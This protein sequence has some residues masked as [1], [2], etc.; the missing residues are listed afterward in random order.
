MRFSLRALLVVILGISVLC[1]LLFSVPDRFAL[2]I[3][4][5]I[6]LHAT[7]AMVLGIVYFDREVRAF[8]V[9]ASAGMANTVLLNMLYSSSMVLEEVAAFLQGVTTTDAVDDYFFGKLIFVYV[10]SVSLTGGWI[11]VLA[12]QFACR[13]KRHACD[14]E[15]PRTTESEQV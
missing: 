14:S 1:A 10:L 8:C 15:L 11:G 9:G 13:R 7:V 4:L 5:M 6:S 2:F 12:R 3:L